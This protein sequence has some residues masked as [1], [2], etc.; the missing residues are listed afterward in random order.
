[1][2]SS[3]TAIRARPAARRAPTK[4]RVA[5]PAPLRTPTSTRKPS[6]RVVDTAAR[7]QTRRVRL[8]A[9]VIGALVVVALLAAVAFHVQLAQGQLELDRLDRETAAARTQY[10]Q[11]RL[12][13]AQQSSPAAIVSRASALGMVPTGDAPTYLVV[14]DAPPSAPAPDQTSTTLQEGWKKVKPHLGT[15]P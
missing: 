6:L 7:V 14:P 4:S 8:I 5:R 10:Q 1:M 3:A 9:W 13:Y 2:S 12:Q 11:L 15:E